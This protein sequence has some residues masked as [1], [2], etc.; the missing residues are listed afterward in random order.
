MKFNIIARTKNITAIE[1]KVMRKSLYGIVSFL[2]NFSAIWK[3]KP[4]II[5]N[6]PILNP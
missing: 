1:R 4:Q 5:I 2:Y 3:A 6:N